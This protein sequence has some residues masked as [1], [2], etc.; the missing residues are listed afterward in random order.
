LT[1]VDLPAPF[2]ADL[3]PLYPDLGDTASAQPADQSPESGRGVL[4]SEP[5]ALDTLIIDDR[6]RVV[7][8]GP[9]DA[10]SQPTST[11]ASTGPSFSV[12]LVAS[13]L[14]LA[15]QVGSAPGGPGTRQP[16]A[17]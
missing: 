9:V 14:P 16:V 4:D 15:Q 8:A 13:S 1:S 12:R 10:G 17:H 2:L 7:L 5:V 3:R 6:D 11:R